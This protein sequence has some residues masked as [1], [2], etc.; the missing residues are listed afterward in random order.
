MYRPVL[1]GAGDVPGAEDGVH[2]HA[3]LLPGV[4]GQLLAGLD[5][6]L[7]GARVQG[8]VDERLGCICSSL[9]TLGQAGRRLMKHSS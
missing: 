8:C 2:A 6:H 9:L 3:Q 5:V 1:D 7:Q 4:G